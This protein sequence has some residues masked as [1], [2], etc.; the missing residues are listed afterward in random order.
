MYLGLCIVFVAF[1][2]IVKLNETKTET[3][4]NIMLQIKHQN[5]KK[6]KVHYAKGEFSSS[7]VKTVYKLHQKSLHFTK[8]KSR[9]LYRP[10]L[11]RIWT[12]SQAISAA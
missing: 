7:C 6:T 3:K 12:M 1:R 8:R 10:F 11:C 9:L 4:L 5:F 2:M